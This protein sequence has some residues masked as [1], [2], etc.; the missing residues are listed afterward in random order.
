MIAGWLKTQILLNIG[1][2]VAAK[3]WPIWALRCSSSQFFLCDADV[4][5]IA[6]PGSKDSMAIR[7][8]RF[9]IERGTG[10]P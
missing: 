3:F 8:R 1:V 10:T 2:V 9:L 6:K 5:G 4:V 7:I